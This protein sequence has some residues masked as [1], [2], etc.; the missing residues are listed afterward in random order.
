MEEVFR[1]SALG[2]DTGRERRVQSG[3]G[4]RL[5]CEAVPEV[6]SPTLQVAPELGRPFGVS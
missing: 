1:G 5:G 6:A 2:N 3:Q 4:E